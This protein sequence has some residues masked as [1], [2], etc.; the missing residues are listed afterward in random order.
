MS[1]DIP[2]LFPFLSPRFCI[3]TSICPCYVSSIVYARLFKDKNFS[4][5]ALF[6]MPFSAYGIRRFVVE[7]LNYKENYETS[8]IKSICC[9]NSL[10]QDLHEMKLRRI[11]IY[12]YMSEPF[13]EDSSEID[14]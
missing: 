14:F 8:A 13:I 5:F 10:V 2:Y 4:F 6:L 12:K 1:Y 7:E 3:F 11:G 9:I